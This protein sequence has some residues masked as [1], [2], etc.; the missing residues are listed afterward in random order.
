MTKLLNDRRKTRKT[1]DGNGLVVRGIH[2]VLARRVQIPLRAAEICLYGL[3]NYNR[4]WIG[5]QCD[6]I[7]EAQEAS[8]ATT[9]KF[10][11]R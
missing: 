6:S 9:L 4:Y 11:K 3:S 10:E 1:G 8:D 2:L 7:A 5:F